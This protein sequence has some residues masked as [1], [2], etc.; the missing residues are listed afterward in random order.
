MPRGSAASRNVTKQAPIQ[1]WECKTAQSSTAQKANDV[2]RSN[3]TPTSA[4]GGV[5]RHHHYRLGTVTLREIRRYQKS[6]ELLIAK[7]P[8]QH[9]VREICQDFNVYQFLGHEL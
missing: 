8:F 4:T 6:V 5:K 2:T 7:E 1:G 3:Q 9:L